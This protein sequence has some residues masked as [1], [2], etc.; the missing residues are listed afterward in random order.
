M[1]TIEK[2]ILFYP[3][4]NLKST[5]RLNSGYYKCK[6]DYS[7]NIPYLQK[8]DVIT[9]ELLELPSN[10]HHDIVSKIELFA[11]KRDEYKKYNF[12]HKRGV[13]LHGKPGSGKTC[14]INIICNNLISKYNAI[15][16]KIGSSE[17]FANLMSLLNLLRIIEPDR[18]LVI[19]FEDIESILKSDLES[20]LLNFLDGNNQVE[21]VIY[22]AT[23]N[24]IERLEERIS[25]RPSRFDDKVYVPYL[26]STDREFIIKYKIK[27]V[28]IDLDMW[29]KATQNMSFAHIIELIKSVFILNED[30]DKSIEKLKKMMNYKK[31]TSENYEKDL[32]PIGFTV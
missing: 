20:V 3:N 14:L 18:L 30:F 5:S 9:D 15:V 27:D 6:M 10:I 2:D 22:F 7:R 11:S 1:W 25:N 8:S 12:V 4:I 23:T 26:T 32:K 16:V 31:E 17:A 13:L 24:Y 29:I 19:I 28:E 21:N